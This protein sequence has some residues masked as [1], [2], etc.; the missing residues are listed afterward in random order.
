MFPGDLQVNWMF[1]NNTIDYTPWSEYA[2]YFGFEPSQ[3][4]RSVPWGGYL[5][6]LFG[7][8]ATFR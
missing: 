8:L 7:S 6:R 3:P 1:Y 4:S 5:G 2:E